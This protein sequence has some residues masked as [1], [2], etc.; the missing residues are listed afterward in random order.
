VL[1]LFVGAPVALGGGAPPPTDGWDPCDPHKMHY[2]QLPDPNGWDVAFWFEFMM[3][4]PYE[5]ADDWQCSKTGPVDDIH[6]WISWQGG[7]QGEIGPVMVSIYSN[8]P[9][10]PYGYSEPNELLWKQ[11]FQGLDAVYYGD[12]DQ[13][14]YDPVMG[15]IPHDHSTYYQINITDI[16]EPFIQHKDQIYWL[17]IQLTPMGVGWKTSLNHFMDNAVVR[18][19]M[20]PCSSSDPCWGELVE[21]PCTSG[22]L[23]FAFVITGEPNEAG[24]QADYGDAPDPAFPSKF[25]SGGP[26]HL[27]LN[28]CYV[29]PLPN[30]VNAE[31]DAQVPDMDADDGEPII[32][33]SQASG[34]WTGWVYV[35]IS[36]AQFAP[37]RDRYLNV[38]LDCHSTG[39]W[40]D[41]PGEWVVRNYL[42]D[43]AYHLPGQTVYYCIGGFSW[44]GDYSGWHW[45][46]VTVSEQTVAAN[47][48]NGW[49]GSVPGAF[50]YG[51]TED[52]KLGWHY[53]PWIGPGIPGGPLPPNGG[54]PPPPQPIP[55]CIK[56]GVIWQEPPP[57]HYGH[58]GTFQICLKN[59]GTHEIHITAGPYPTHLRTDGGSIDVDV[60]S[61]YCNYLEPGEVLCADS[62]WD[63]GENPPPSKAWCDWGAQGDPA[64]VKME[65]DNVGDY[66]SPTSETPTGGIFEE[67]PPKPPVPD[68]KWSQPPIE[69]DPTDPEPRYCGWDQVSLKWY[70]PCDPAGWWWMM[71]AD[72][73]RCFGSMPIDSIHWWGSHLWWD[74]DEP[75]LDDPN[76]IGWQIGFW[77]NVPAGASS[78]P[79]ID[80]S[81]PEELLWQVQVPAARV[82]VK[83]VGI[84]EHPMLEG[85]LETCFQYYVDLEPDEVFWQEDFLADTQD[86]IFW[87]SIAA[88]YPE[89]G[90]PPDPCY[91]DPCHPWGWKTRPWSWMDDG[92]AFDLFEDPVPGTMIDPCEMYLLEY[93]GESYD[94]A[95]ELDT[96]PNWIKWDQA[97][98]GIRHW[99][100]YEDIASWAEIQDEVIY[101]MVVAADDWKC[102]GP[103]PVTALAWYGSYLGYWY[104]PCSVD[105]DKQQP[106][107]PEKPAYFDVSIWTDVPADPCDQTMPWSHPGEI[108]WQYDVYN[109]DEVLVGYDKYPHDPCGNPISG[110]HEP[111]FRYTARIPEEEWFWQDPNEDT[112]YWLSIMAVYDHYPQYEWGWTN[113]QHVYNDDAVQAYP[114]PAKQQWYWSEI[115]DQTGASADLSFTIYTDPYACHRPL[116][117]PHLCGL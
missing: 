89:P 114:G 94:L 67:E 39:K 105:P 76:V 66:T 55:E 24:P 88:M 75:P 117:L 58:S 29:G 91:S 92:V 70:D 17:A 77:S 106:P 59:T 62:S 1:V 6:F 115:Y 35:P 56:A 26:H 49:D 42:L 2:P 20:D 74:G 41:L 85:F 99:P 34:I 46:R 71:A 40:C 25:A 93:L 102:Q 4:F 43:P 63:W 73:F 10:G 3:F 79:F 50:Q 23:D 65:I 21:D 13:G 68:L 111:V 107:P 16:E 8:D 19:V 101:H 38:L 90:I 22:P 83:R 45:L 14:W 81:Y 104:H 116:R 95:F 80:F 54:N 7:M 51:E 103:E 72:D 78:D 112:V 87:L 61:L 100:H 30:T 28:D 109:F 57:T 32:F 47:V 48:P 69:Y 27:I 52:W 60:E 36:I 11:T 82:Q 44:V 86:D 113:H 96:D 110:P 15:Q 9:C 98:T 5:L 97:Y 12:G 108:V 33:A 18:I 31:A 84:D 37:P 53:D 64:G